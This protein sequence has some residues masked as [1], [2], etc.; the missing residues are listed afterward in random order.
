MK[1]VKKER[2]KYT[3]YDTEL[4]INFQVK[5][6]INTKVRFRV[7]ENFG[8]R[9]SGHKYS[10]ICENVSA[11]GLCFAAGKKMKK[12]DLLMLSVY[13]PNSKRPVKMEGQVRWSR[14]LPGREKG[15]FNCHTG[16]LLVA[17]N[18]K[19]LADSIYFD[20]QYD[21]IWSAALNSLFGSFAAMANKPA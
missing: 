6:D 2:R 7:V 16:V 13:P 19:S 17:V 10:G 14:K 5:Y 12:G 18:G 8:K 1:I 20:E 11:Q 21:V 9:V 15:R 4:K 3:H